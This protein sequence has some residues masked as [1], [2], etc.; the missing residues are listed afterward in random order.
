MLTLSELICGVRNID[1]DI[2]SLAGTCSVCGCYTESAH[3]FKDTG[4]FTTYQ[5]LL[6]GG[7]ICPSCF[8]MRKNRGND[9][10]ILKD[11]VIMR[12]I[13]V[14]DM[15]ANWIKP[16]TSIQTMMLTYQPPYWDRSK[17]T[18]CVAPGGKIG[19]A[20]RSDNIRFIFNRL[21]V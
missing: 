7:I 17:A 21:F 15:P 8:E 12:P 14:K 5:Y 9:Y 4:S 1:P 13:P 18:E 16:G 3:E 19:R 6:G 11:N 10:S 20:E 2:G